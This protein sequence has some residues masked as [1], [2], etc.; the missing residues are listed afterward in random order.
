MVKTPAILVTTVTGPDIMSS[1]T[2]LPTVPEIEAATEVLSSLEKY[3]KVALDAIIKLQDIPRPDHLGA[4]KR[5][6]YHDGA[7]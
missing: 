1:E 5:Q 2:N 3:A 7:F 4:L 6:P